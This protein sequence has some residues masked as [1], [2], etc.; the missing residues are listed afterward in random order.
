[1]GVPIH[2]NKEYRLG[3]LLQVDPDPFVQFDQWF[4]QAGEAMP[5]DMVNSMVLATVSPDRQP[6]ARVVLLKEYS[7]AGF[8]FYTNYSSRKGND[9][10]HNP[11]V[12]LLFWWEALE[13]QVRI[14]GQAKKI[15]AEQSERYFHTRPKSSQL[16][17][18]VSKQSQVLTSREALQNQ[19]DTVCQQYA[20]AE[21]TI[22]RPDY[23]GGYIVQPERFEYWQGRE[24]RLHDRFQ[25]TRLPAN[26]WQIVR[27]FP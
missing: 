12:S 22:H 1:M 8:V 25:Y 9:I 26:H 6:S 2:R 20:G 13:R 5:A 4:H 24:N 10:A 16:A 11:A 19:F 14:E 15:S 7:P 23:W 18:L 3:Q 17:T 27:L 21:L